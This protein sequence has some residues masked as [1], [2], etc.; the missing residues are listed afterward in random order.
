MSGELRCMYVKKPAG[1]RDSVLPVL[2]SGRLARPPGWGIPII[3]L[4]P[5]HDVG[6]ALNT[7]LI[8]GVPR[9]WRI[10]G[11]ACRPL[12]LSGPSALLLIA[13]VIAP[14]GLPPSLLL[15]F[16]RLTQAG[17]TVNKA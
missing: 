6:M 10:A 4:V 13:W 11:V 5:R 15:R 1:W 2:P 12:I 3:R 14:G 7:V 8:G 9:S 17:E 16:R